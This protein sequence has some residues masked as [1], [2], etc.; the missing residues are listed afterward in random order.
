MAFLPALFLPG[1]LGALLAT[2][3]SGAAWP[4]VY[5]MAASLVFIGIIAI[6]AAWLN[7]RDHK[8]RQRERSAT[9]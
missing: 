7:S 2:E 8:R 6:P 9:R 3:V 4:W 5:G 1:P